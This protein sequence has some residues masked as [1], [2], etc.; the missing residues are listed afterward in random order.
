MDKKEVII[1]MKSPVHANDE[2]ELTGAT[3]TPAEPDSARYDDSI[4]NISRI[5]NHQ[6]AALKNSPIKV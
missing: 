6:V 5:H 2:L 4:P 3:I 1:Q